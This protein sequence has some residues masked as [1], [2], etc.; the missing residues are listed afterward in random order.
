MTSEPVGK[1]KIKK[2]CRSMGHFQMVDFPAKSSDTAVVTRCAIAEVNLNR[3]SEGCP[4]FIPADRVLFFWP[5]P[6]MVIGNLPCHS[7]LVVAGIFLGNGSM[8]TEVDPKT[9]PMDR[10]PEL[11]KYRV[12]A[13]R[14]SSGVAVSDLWATEKNTYTFCTCSVAVLCWSHF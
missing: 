5:F 3:R 9:R 13:K 2:R 8:D 10:K 11:S 1:D 14:H 12:N 7:R 6:K 4:L